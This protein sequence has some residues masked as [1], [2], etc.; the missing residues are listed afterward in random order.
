MDYLQKS[1]A[2]LIVEI[3]SAM[4]GAVARLSAIHD[5]DPMLI[6]I[7]AASYSMAIKD[8]DKVEPGFKMLMYKLLQPK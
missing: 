3:A 5:N 4:N 8:L 7:I 6:E 2:E 1:R